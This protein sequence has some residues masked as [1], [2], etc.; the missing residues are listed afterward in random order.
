MDNYS[1]ET[2]L[3]VI[4][5]AIT[6]N[7]FT[8]KPGGLNKVYSFAPEQMEDLKKFRDNI[9]EYFEMKDGAIDVNSI[10]LEEIESESFPYFI[11]F[12]SFDDIFPDSISFPK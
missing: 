4:Q 10:I 7:T 11:F 2:I 6:N 9:L 3:N 5:T 1:E 8:F 12:D